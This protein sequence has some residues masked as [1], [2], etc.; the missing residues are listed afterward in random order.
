MPLWEKTSSCRGL[1]FP[2]RVHLTIGGFLKGTTL[3]MVNLAVNEYSF[4]FLSKEKRKRAH[5]LLRLLV[6][7]SVQEHR[8]FSSHSPSIHCLFQWR[9]P[10]DDSM[11]H[12]ILL[13]HALQLCG[14][15]KYRGNI[16]SVLLWEHG[17][18]R[19]FQSDRGKKIAL[20]SWN[21]MGGWWLL[22]W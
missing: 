5:V 20:S 9:Q 13:F 17:C 22:G 7:V 3:L 1:I 21:C 12:N 10:G 8:S 16:V 6:Q 19:Y 2:H 14:L 11:Y 15:K 4:L 18:H